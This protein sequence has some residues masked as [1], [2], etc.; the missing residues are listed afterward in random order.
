LEWELVDDV[1]THGISGNFTF[2][3]C[4]SNTTMLHYMQ[5]KVLHLLA[6]KG[7]YFETWEQPAQAPEAATAY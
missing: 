2:D 1:I 3:R 4:F 6:L 7:Y 5:W